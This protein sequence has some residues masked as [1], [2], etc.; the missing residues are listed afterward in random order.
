[1]YVCIINKFVR[2]AKV[3][4]N[5]E[6]N[7]QNRIGYNVAAYFV[8]SL[9]PPHESSLLLLSLFRLRPYYM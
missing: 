2:I 6:V 8:L 1:M 9:P 5:M 3:V 4:C 7:N